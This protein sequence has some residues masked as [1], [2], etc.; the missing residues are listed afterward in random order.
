MRDDESFGKSGGQAAGGAADGLLTS[1]ELAGAL[2]VSV[3]TVAQLVS[4]RKI[5]FIRIGAKC[6]RFRLPAVM[7]A[8]EVSAK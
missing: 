5:P 7:A 1:K 6:L 8:F 2:R 3:R 4:D